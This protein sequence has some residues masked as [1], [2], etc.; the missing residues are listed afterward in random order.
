MGF[1]PGGLLALVIVPGAGAAAAFDDGSSSQS[2]PVAE[3]VVGD[4]V[5]RS[6]AELRPR[7]I[8]WDRAT[9]A[10]LVHLGV[11]ISKCWDIAAVQRLLVGG[12][13]TDPARAWA[14]LHDP[15]TLPVKG[16]FQGRVG[17]LIGACEVVVEET[18]DTDRSVRRTTEC[19]LDGLRI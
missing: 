2:W 9:T 17:Q 6:E 13:R 19:G 1:E 5:R 7:W 11:R 14:E 4:F 8:V 18:V 15:S 16:L 10:H 12:W 3:D